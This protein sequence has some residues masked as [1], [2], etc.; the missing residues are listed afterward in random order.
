MVT[1][2]SFF[3]AA[4]SFFQAAFDAGFGVAAADVLPAE[5][6]WLADAV[7]PNAAS[8]AT[9]RIDRSSS[10]IWLRVAFLPT[11]LSFPRW[12]GCSA[13]TKFLN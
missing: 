4:T 13:A 12:C 8:S 11:E 1:L 3:A 2:P 6:A 9:T 7:L 5:T 10:R